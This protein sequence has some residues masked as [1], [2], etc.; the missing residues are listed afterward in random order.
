MLHLCLLSYQKTTSSTGTKATCWKEH[1]YLHDV[2][3]AH[4][5][6]TQL[7]IW[8]C[9]NR[10]GGMVVK[11]V[12]QILSQLLKAASSK[13]CSRWFL[14]SLI[15]F[16][17][18]SSLYWHPPVCAWVWSP[19][20]HPVAL[21]AFAVLS[22]PLLLWPHSLCD[23]FGP[24]LSLKK[25]AIKPGP[26]LGG[27]RHWTLWREDFWCFLSF[28]AKENEIIK[29]S[30]LREVL[31]AASHIGFIGWILFSLGF[32]IFLSYYFS[33]HILTVSSVI[34]SLLVPALWKNFSTV[35]HFISVIII[36]VFPVR[37][38]KLVWGTGKWKEVIFLV[39]ICFE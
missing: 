34:H 31:A 27:S 24:P 33:C 26:L 22:S 11:I 2:C 30:E 19:W 20:V 39:S 38:C 21:S 35:L 18:C 12:C 1:I 37:H 10:F 15:I 25:D 13:H 16:R 7:Y 8:R 36:S 6:K 4:S 5:L 29:T 9:F 14:S 23:P 28:R 17:A 3:L 32:Q